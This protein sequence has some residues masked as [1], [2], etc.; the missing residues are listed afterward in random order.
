MSKLR[1]IHLSID[2][3]LDARKEHFSLRCVEAIH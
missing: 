2:V 3:F 1:H